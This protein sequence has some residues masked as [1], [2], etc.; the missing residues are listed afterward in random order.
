MRDALAALQPTELSQPKLMAT[1]PM[2]GWDFPLQKH[3]TKKKKLPGSCRQA[4]QSQLL[5]AGVVP[6]PAAGVSLPAAE[7]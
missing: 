3:H 2:L 7:G 5:A 1:L 6:L 4:V